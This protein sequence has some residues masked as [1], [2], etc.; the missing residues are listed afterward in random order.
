MQIRP[1]RPRYFSTRDG[2]NKSNQRKY[3]TNEIIRV[4]SVVIPDL[5]NQTRWKTLFCRVQTPEMK[6][7]RKQATIVYL[8]EHILK[9]D[10]SKESRTVD[11]I[12]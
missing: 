5:N 7:L 2:T 4:E 3:I 1:G 8:V 10:L 12:S 11:W 6:L 9:A